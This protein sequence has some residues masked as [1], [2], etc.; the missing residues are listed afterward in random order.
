LTER[1][2]VRSWL[3][4]SLAVEDLLDSLEA[5]GVAVRAS[6]DP[7]AL[8]R[9]IPLEDFP[10]PLRRSA[11]RALPVYLAFFCLENSVRTLVEER[12]RE[13]HGN[14]WWDSCSTSEIQRRV[15]DRRAKEGKQRWHARRG[16]SEVFY[17][18][19]GD[20]KALIRNNWA[21]FE[22]LLPDQHWVSARLD[23]LEA[24]RNVI[25]H[26]NMLDDREIARIKM[27]LEDWIRQVG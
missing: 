7:S 19:F 27:Y 1:E 2:G 24:S 23:E 11:M 13:N 18:D 21:D 5:D 14:D 25:A 4:R 6:S 3:F 20:L 17:T 12:L 22:D 9:V 16:E 8:Q 10:A 15:D 26:S